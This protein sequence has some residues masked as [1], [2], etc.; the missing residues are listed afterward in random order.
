MPAND[1]KE[2]VTLLQKH[3]VNYFTVGDYAVGYHVYPRYTWDLDIWL[4]PI[5]S[6][7]EKIIL[8]VNEFGFSSLKLTLEDFTK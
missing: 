8:A 1:F 7:A 2:F 4:N 6:N 3:S 5:K